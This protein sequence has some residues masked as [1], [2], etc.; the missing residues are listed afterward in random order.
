ML[1]GVLGGTG[2]LGRQVVTELERRGHSAAVLSRSPGPRPR[3]HRRVDV[4]SGEGLD[5]AMADLEVLVDVLHGPEPVLVDGLGRALTATRAAGVRSV[6]SISI[7]GADRVP[8]GYYRVKTAQEAAVQASRLP[9][10]ILR[11]TQFHSLLDTVF[12][13]SARRGVLPMLRVPL[14]P[15]APEEVAARLVNLAESGP[16]GISR[17]AGPR[18]QRADHLARIWAR[19]RGVRWVP[20]PV[21]ALGS[22]LK[23]VRAGNLTDPGAPAGHIPF[24][25]WLRV[26]A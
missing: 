1:V 5:T 22:V 26:A 16:A 15:V 19:A 3:L 4:A 6:V 12:T 7:L 20:V 14:Q 23:A 18:V 11:A 13:Q 8:L 24:E 10:S 17:F 21:P 9:W 25:A 2:A